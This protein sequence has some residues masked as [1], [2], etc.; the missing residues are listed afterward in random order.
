MNR[1]KPLVGKRDARIVGGSIDLFAVALTRPG[2][3][4]CYKVS[5][6][7]RSYVAIGRTSRIV[8][9]L[10]VGVDVGQVIRHVCFAITLVWDVYVDGVRRKAGTKKPVVKRQALTGTRLCRQLGLCFRT[11][12]LECPFNPARVY[13]HPAYTLLHIHHTGHGD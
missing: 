8:V 11:Q 1:E 4:S 7:P 9:D 10:G 13:I 2:A 6:N 3:L 12:T 5:S